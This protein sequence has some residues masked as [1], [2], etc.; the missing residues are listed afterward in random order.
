MSNEE[1]PPR[2]VVRDRRAFTQQGER[3]SDAP[4][5]SA[6][7]P[8]PVIGEARPGERKRDSAKKNSGRRGKSG[9][10]T[11]PRDERRVQQLIGMLF[12]Q[13]VMVLNQTPAGEKDQAAQDA[14]A[15]LQELIDMLEVFQEKTRGRIGPGDE[16][17]LDRAL[18]Q[19]RMEFMARRDPPVP[20]P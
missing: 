2:I 13:A 1:S 20:T 10:G 3:R 18:Y 16:R 9:P 14:L 11:A 19:L 4:P 17:L 8:P 12:N 15:V 6:D 5:P 7:S